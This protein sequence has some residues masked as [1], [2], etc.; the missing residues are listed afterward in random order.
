MCSP[1]TV[2]IISRSVLLGV[3]YISEKLVEKV[4]TRVLCSITFSKFAFF[5][6][7]IRVF[8]KLNI[9][10]IMLHSFGGDYFLCVWE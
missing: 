1:C 3:R 10:Y 4:K 8:S 5:F 9:V 7:E 6:F 2:L